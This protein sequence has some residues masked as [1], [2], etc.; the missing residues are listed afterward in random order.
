ME[1]GPKEKKAAYQVMNLEGG[2]TSLTVEGGGGGK[3]RKIKW[4]S[5]NFAVLG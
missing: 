1:G 2:K 5:E 4:L 3:V